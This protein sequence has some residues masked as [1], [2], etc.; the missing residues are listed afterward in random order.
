[1]YEAVKIEKKWQKIWEEKQPFRIDNSPKKKYYVLEMFPYPSGKLHMGHLRNYSIGDVIARF[2]RMNGFD[3][4][5][6]MGYDA[7]GLPA[8]NAA[9]K[10][11]THPAKWTFD[12]IE[13]I[14]KQQKL[15]G[16]SYD[17]KREIATCKE[18]YYKWNQWIF[19]KMFDRGLAYRKK[20]GVNWCSGCETV[21]A[22]EQV[23][24]GKCWRCKTEVVQKELEQWFFKITEYADEL[25]KDMEQ[26][27]EWPERVRTMQE[28]WI[29]KS[30]GAEIDF[31]IKG[32]DKKICVFT[33]RSD[34]L[35]GATYVVL[36]PEH[37]LVKEL[38]KGTKYENKVS[39]FMEKIK[40]KNMLER[41]SKGKD[42]LFIGAYA[43]NPANKKEVPIYIAD[44][45]VM[46]YGTGAI[47]A[48]PSH[49]ERDYEFAQK[50]NLEIINVI[51]HDT[52]EKVY[53]GDGAL[54]NS[55]K[56]DGMDNKFA[57]DKII[58]NVGGRKV[59][60]YKLRDWL[61]SRQ[62]YWGTPI[63][64]IY[65]EKCGVLPLPEDELP[66][67][68][69]EDVSFTGHGN[70]LD[71]ESFT[72][73][74]CHK[75]SSDAKRETD[76]M[77]TFVDS[78]W[79]FLRYCSP[80]YEK[81]MFDKKSMVWMPVDQYIGGIEHA[82][83]HLL[84]ARFFTKVLRDMDMLKFHEP[85]K[86][87]LAQGM[88]TKDGTKM[89]KSIGNVVDPQEIID[90]YGADT[91]RL[92]MLAAALPEKELE[93]NDKGVQAIY[94]FLN[95][96]YELKSSTVMKASE[97]EN[98]I[99]LVSTNTVLKRVTEYIEDYKFNFAVLELIKLSD[100]LKNYPEKN[101]KIFNNCYYTFLKMMLPFAPHMAE[102]LWN[103]GNESLLSLESWPHPDKKYL[104]EIYEMRQK[105]IE[106]VFDD[107]KNIEKITGIKLKRIKLFAA[108]QW[109]YDVYNIAVNHKDPL[110]KCMENHEIKK[111]GRDVI[112][113]LSHI[114]S[115]HKY[116]LIL[117]RKQELDVLNK[118]KP[119]LEK[120]FGAEVVI[121]EITNPKAKPGKPAILLE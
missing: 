113:Y 73:T 59:V 70:P 15:L 18:G 37:A 98:E 46:G 90:K 22:N 117:D 85:F 20:A 1:V 11:K 77:D 71:I 101:S 68:L 93:W 62:R 108:E 55:E 44:Y 34:T 52:K 116:K 33:T 80:D 51:K 92:F 74:I 87:L 95:R 79:Y 56:F 66:V 121:E 41:T 36:A 83:L 96:V 115:F 76:T 45:V 111:H 26:L 67:K 84:Y 3:V 119:I 114:H 25:L 30:Y 61:I 109:I 4:L 48:V 78:S 12:A 9:I 2:K 57:M 120:N 82:V 21:L 10:N 42:G 106:T 49:D 40:K 91:A 35:Y 32:I 7:F 72:K 5:Y 17:W 75:C 105:L 81:A 88:V 63:P 14:K 16:L 24:N 100:I 97:I 43:I 53:T 50:H 29:G 103:D 94:K 27:T 89:S 69:P 58:E 47:M 86:R 39:K 107:I 60:Q 118:L 102:E 28:N 64:V 8:E 54:I 31:D 65:C 104:G 19:L 6:P 99:L 112:K 23:E 13:S 110:K 38:V